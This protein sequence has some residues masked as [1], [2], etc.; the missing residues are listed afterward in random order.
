MSDWMWLSI[1]ILEMTLV[2]ADEITNQRFRW[3][4]RRHS[5]KLNRDQIVYIAYL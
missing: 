2:I 5:L 4:L 1:G 3:L